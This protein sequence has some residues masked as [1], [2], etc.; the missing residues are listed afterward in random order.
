MQVRRRGIASAAISVLF[1]LL[2]LTSM[3]IVSLSSS[4]SERPLQA[5]VAQQASHGFVHVVP[6]SLENYG[7]QSVPSP[8]QMLVTVNSAQY[9]Q[10]EAANL[11]NVEFTYPNG[12]VIPSWIQAGN[13]NTA[14]HTPYWLRLLGGIPVDSSITVDLDF[15][16][17]SVSFFNNLTVG[18]AAPLSPVYGQFDNGRTV[19]SFYD[20]FAGNTL[21]PDLWTVSTSTS[22]TVSNGLTVS[23][24]G[25]GYVLSTAQFSPE[26]IFEADVTSVGDVNEVGFLNN[27]VPLPNPSA[28]PG[29]F[30]RVACGVTYPDQWNAA[31]EANGCAGAYGAL[32]STEGVSG[33]YEV[34]SL[35]SSSSFSYLNGGIG[36]THQPVTTNAPSYPCRVGFAGGANSIGVTWALARVLPPGG[37]MP[38]VVPLYPVTFAESGL[39]SGTNW[40]VTVGSI[41][42]SSTGQTHTLNEP[43][44][45]YAYTIS[46]VPGWHQTTLP[47]T[48]TVAVS[49]ATVTEPTLAFAQVTDSVTFS[50]SGLPSGTE[51]DVNL[52]SGPSHSSTTGTITFSEPNGTYAYTIGDVPGWHQTT[53]PYTGTVAVSGATVTEPTLAFAQVTD[54]VTFSESGLPSGT[55]WDV[56]LTSGPSHSSTTGTITF[57][58]PN[59]TYAYTIGDVP[60]WHQTTLPYTGTVAVSGATVTEPTLAFAQVTDSVTFSESGLPSGT[61]WDVNLTSGPSHSS[62]TGTITFSEP[63]GTYQFTVGTGASYVSTFSNGTVVVAGA[64]A[65]ES[66][67]FT[68]AY[69]VTFNSPSGAT[70]GVP[71]TVYLNSTTGPQTRAAASEFSNGIVRTTTAAS[72][73]ILAPNGTYAYSIVVSGSPA[74]TIQGTLTVS[75]SP[76]VANPPPTANT[77]LGFSGLTGYYILAAVVV[78]AVVIAVLVVVMRRKPPTIPVAAPPPT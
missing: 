64:P 43:N 45:T 26:T 70:A 41:A 2:L 68:F 42:S 74:L 76:L 21:N 66:V 38:S 71:W 51:W 14:T 65:T 58:E 62:T 44:G 22:V 16:A 63:N 15:G 24:S 35:S 25:D 31:G 23:Y 57:S 69:A 5:R 50:E 17:Q 56:N 28:Y 73:T 8:F 19:F 37:V 48:G 59:G 30:I 75:G 1:C 72:L 20:N 77:F 52:T 10:Y 47:Y 39:P 55:E 54:S 7:S 11:Q 13:S 6:L 67:M 18:E 29:A 78:A 12:T 33:V 4:V 60:G 32:A 36:N 49:G 9:A 3:L 34:D 46:D 27:T 61:E 53:L 40:S